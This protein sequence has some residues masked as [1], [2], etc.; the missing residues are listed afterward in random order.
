MSIIRF[1]TAIIWF[2]LNNIIYIAFYGSA[3]WIAI[4]NAKPGI[5]IF[6]IST[7][8]TLLILFMNMMLTNK[9]IHI[10]RTTVRNLIYRLLVVAVIIV[11]LI[12]RDHWYLASITLLTTIL[13]A[14]LN[15]GRKK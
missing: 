8:L 13:S 9:I 6:Y 1:I 14:K 12:V 4:N 5:I 10:E 15:W 2:L 11:V 3:L 7:H